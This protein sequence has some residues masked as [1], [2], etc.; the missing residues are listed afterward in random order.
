[1]A[2]GTDSD[3]GTQEKTPPDPPEQMAEE[4]E[5]ARLAGVSARARPPTSCP[6]EYLP[7]VQPLHEKLK[8]LLTEYEIPWRIQAQLAD[9]GYQWISDVAARYDDRAA[10]MRHAPGHYQFEAGSNG[11]GEA[12][13]KL[14][15]GRLA[16]MMDT[17]KSLSK[18]RMG[19][20]LTQ[21]PANEDLWLPSNKETAKRCV[22]LIRPETI[23]I[24]SIQKTRVVITSW[25][26]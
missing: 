26:S 15:A 7:K 23:T 8:L 24:A 11:Y 17:A 18:E 20:L 14:V 13:S 21:Q 25:R 9:E 3:L 6:E 2:A 1:M 16:S 4:A 19:E 22:G 5:R 10:V 12:E